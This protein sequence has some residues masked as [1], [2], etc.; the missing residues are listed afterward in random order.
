MARVRN[1]GL[2]FGLYRYSHYLCKTWEVMRF[3]LSQVRRQLVQ[4]LI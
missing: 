3:L 4:I 1:V 2:S